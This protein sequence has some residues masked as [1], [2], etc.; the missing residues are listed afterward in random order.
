MMVMCCVCECVGVG[1]YVGV[2]VGGGCVKYS[3]QQ[4]NVNVS[5]LQNDRRT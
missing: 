2:V 3:R 1:T 4:Y 5:F